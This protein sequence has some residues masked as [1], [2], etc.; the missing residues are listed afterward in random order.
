MSNFTWVA[1]NIKYLFIIFFLLLNIQII[2]QNNAI[3]SLTNLIEKE[4]YKNRESLRKVELLNLLADEYMKISPTIALYNA[5]EAVN[6]SYKLNDTSK[7]FYIYYT[8]GEIYCEQ[9]LYDK[10]LEYYQKILTYSKEIVPDWTYVSIGNVLY[11]KNDFLKARQYYDF[12]LQLFVENNNMSGHATVLNNIGLIYNKLDMSDSALIVFE[13][14][15]IIREELGIENN[16][17]LSYR[18]IGNT[19]LFAGNFDK[20]YKYF[21]KALELY[22]KESDNKG[23]GESLIF[24]GD[25]FIEKQEIYKAKDYYLQ[26]V[27]ICIESSNSSGIA[28]SYIRISNIYFSESNFEK[29]IEYAEKALEIGENNNLLIVQQKTLSILYKTYIELEDY[30]QVFFYRE[31]YNIITDS[32]FNENLSKQILQLELK[33]AENEH[34]KVIQL[35]KKDNEIQEIKLRSKTNLIYWF[36]IVTVIILALVLSNL[37]RFNYKIKLAKQ[38]SFDTSIA[39][40][41]G[42]I[43][44]TGVYYTIVLFLFQPFGSSKLA[45]FQ[46]IY[47]F[48][49]MGLISMFVL[50]V[51]FI[52]FYLLERV[53]NK[54]KWEIFRYFLFI[55][56]II[57]GISV[58]EWV[59]IEN[60]ISIDTKL[61][62]FLGILITVFALTIF[63]VFVIVLFIEKIFL[64]KHIHMAELL[65][66]YIKDNENKMI[67]KLVILKSDKT[68]EKIELLLSEII[69]IE[70]KGNYSEIYY[71]KNETFK[72]ILMLI[73]LKALS[74]QLEKH[75]TIVRC[76]KS[77]IV[78][79]SRINNV[80]GNSQGY[81]LNFSE[82]DK[83]IPVSRIFPKSIIKTLKK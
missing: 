66:H 1:Y 28:N 39:S 36:I 45:I 2:A 3:D 18:Y 32:I 38:F 78:N 17:A 74:K 83:K 30:K 6:I 14:A 29:S 82:F 61:F 4:S 43:L 63:P 73:S 5:F 54:G 71:S 60:F 68:K 37:R 57:I 41:I 79:L 67:D 23:I 75:E 19:Y 22:K 20:A 47:V 48:G 7:I 69:Y 65:S 25:L 16:I 53:L 72:K 55:L 24:I 35:L 11:A 10:A 33:F 44:I 50:F 58:L 70:A 76:H 15:L 62:N 26:A 56:S 34:R 51:N 46:K 13:K 8:I 77:F 9:G 80:I 42:I 52:V 27:N 31:K 21:T 12:A 40:K 81:K 64:K 49:G 59:L